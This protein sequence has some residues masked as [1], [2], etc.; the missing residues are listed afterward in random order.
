MV[1]TSVRRALLLG[2][3]WLILDG[4]AG[5]LAISRVAGQTKGD[6]KS[7]PEPKALG[8]DVV[9]GGGLE[10]IAFINQQLETKWK[11]NKLQHADRCSDYEFIRRVTLDIVGRIAKVSEIKEYM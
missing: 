7:Q 8:N 10:Q 2:I 6:A 9:I 5:P 1:R 3:S 11:E 4:L